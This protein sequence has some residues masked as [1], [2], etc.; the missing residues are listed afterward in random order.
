MSEVVNHWLAKRNKTR[1]ITGMATTLACVPLLL[2]AQQS[3]EPAVEEVI[4]TGSYLRGSPLDA[5]S[6]VQVVDRQSIEAQGAAQIWDVIKNLEINSGSITNEGSDGGNAAMGNVSGMANVNLRNLGENSTLTLINGK[7]QVAAATTTPTGGEFV[8]INTIPLVMV[9]RLEVLTDG[10]SALYGSDAVAGVVNV[11]MRTQFEGL[12]IY[13]DVQA[14][15]SSTGNQDKTASIIWGWANDSGT[16]HFVV[17]GEVFHRDPVPLSAARYFD[18]KS[19]F[20]GSVG[21]LG[22]VVNNPGFGSN[23]NMDYVN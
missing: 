15:A 12:E 6:P 11:I 10:G 8:D 1:I 2:Q 19:E 20:T 3:E 16:T 13:G 5:P 22:V 17:S 7:R 4:V 14:L 23:L 9:E 21:G 18:D